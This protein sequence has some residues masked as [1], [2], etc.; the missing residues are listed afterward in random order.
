MTTLSFSQVG[1]YFPCQDSPPEG[2]YYIN[3]KVWVAH[4]NNGNGPNVAQVTST[5]AGVDAY[6]TPHNIFFNYCIEYVV[7]ETIIQDPDLFLYGTCGNIVYDDPDRIDILLIIPPSSQQ[8]AGQA[9]QLGGNKAWSFIPAQNPNNPNNPNPGNSFTMAHELSHLLS[10]IHTHGDPVNTQTTSNCIT[11]IPNHP[12]WQSGDPL[13]NQNHADFVQDTPVH[14]VSGTGTVFTSTMVYNACTIDWGATRDNCSNPSFFPSNYDGNNQTL[15]ENIMAQEFP[16]GCTITKNFTVGQGERMRCYIEQDKQRFLAQESETCAVISNNCITI[17]GDITSDIVFSAPCYNIVSDLNIVGA[18]VQFINS[19]I[20]V[21]NSANGD[22]TSISVMNG[23]TL[24]LFNSDCGYNQCNTWG[25]LDVRRDG[26]LNVFDSYVGN[27]AELNVISSINLKFGRSLFKNIG[28][29]NFERNSPSL[30]NDCAFDDCSKINIRATNINLPGTK[31]N[32]CR[33]DA[34]GSRLFFVASEDHLPTF[35]SS[36]IEGRNLHTLVIDDAYFDDNSGPVSVDGGGDIMI[37]RTEF[38]NCLGTN[39]GMVDLRDVSDYLVFYN[40]FQS[41]NL[42]CIS[43]LSSGTGLIQNNIFTGSADNINNFDDD[44]DI[45]CNYHEGANNAWNNFANNLIN[46]GNLD[47]PA[48]NVFDGVNLGI[49]NNRGSFN[50]FYNQNNSLEEPTVDGVDLD[51]VPSNFNALGANHCQPRSAIFGLFNTRLLCYPS[52]WNNNWP[53]CSE[54]WCIPA[55]EDQEPNECNLPMPTRL[56]GRAL[57]DNDDIEI[58]NG[59][60]TPEGINYD[61][62]IK[63][64]GQNDQIK[65]WPNPVS[66]VIHV[67][68]Y[69][70][71]NTLKMYDTNSKIVLERRL[72]NGMTEI[73][74]E[75]IPIGIYTA[76]ITSSDGINKHVQK[77]IKQ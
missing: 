42:T 44:V 56:N 14:P 62:P 25:K 70:K 71:D 7:D 35:H 27:C 41:S 72:Q 2:P 15:E 33:I 40:Y 23:G 60:L 61:I 8:S 37:C 67:I 32:E 54:T 39:L 9:N 6:Y 48:G 49:A 63:N 3:V 64:R 50:Y 28:T 16:A 53:E 22:V 5:L 57:S 52:F 18:E 66:D 47:H 12:N 31:F 26:T 34:S 17:G 69:N 30:I 38:D 20:H 51:L 77:I 65:I 24:S 45:S 68:T 43:S 21:H 55:P 59:H 75:N 29:I 19:K 13:S 36:S 58:H 73:S 10:L 11:D 76:I 46:Q 74:V 4:D 1:V